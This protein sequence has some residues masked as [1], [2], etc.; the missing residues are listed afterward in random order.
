[1]RTEQDRVHATELRLPI[2]RHHLAVGQ[3]VVAAGP[4][5]VGELQL[6][7][8]APGRGA[9][10]AQTLGHHLPADTIAWNHGNLECHGLLPVRLRIAWPPAW[11]KAH[12]AS[13]AQ[14]ACPAR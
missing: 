1:D 5:D 11:R 12:R 13:P 6:D 14:H 3:V 10:H 4:V 2:V 8:E 9:E 7:A